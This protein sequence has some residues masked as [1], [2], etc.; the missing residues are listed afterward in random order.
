MRISDVVFSEVISEN[1]FKDIK[2]IDSLVIDKP[3]SEIDYLNTKFDLKEN[4]VIFCN[5]EYL[6]TLFTKLNKVDNLNNLKLITQWS[7]RPITKNYLIKNQN[8]FQTGMQVMLTTIMTIYIQYL[9]VYLEIILQKLIKKT[10][11]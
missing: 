9:W 7:D 10:F 3:Y 2:S 4:Y 11:C 8:V 1:E 6:E 5:T